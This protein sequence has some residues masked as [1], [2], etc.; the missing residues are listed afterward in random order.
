[1]LRSY[2]GLRE[3]TRTRFI[4]FIASTGTSIGMSFLGLVLGHEF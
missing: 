2:S 1:M 4:G 3:D